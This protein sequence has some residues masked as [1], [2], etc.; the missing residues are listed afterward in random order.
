M[1]RVKKIVRV[2]RPPN[3]SEK[4]VMKLKTII[5]SFTFLTIST[6]LAGLFI[7]YNTMKTTALNTDKIVSET[8]IKNINDSISQLISR[9]NKIALTLS[10]HEEIA[11]ALK[12]D[13]ETRRVQANKILDLFNSSIETSVCYLLNQ[14]GIAIASSNRNDSDSFLGNDYSFRPYYKES[15]KGNSFVYLAYGVTSGRRGIYFSQPVYAPDSGAILGVVVVKEDTDK[16]ENDILF[17]RYPANVAQDDVIVISNEDG[18]VFISGRKELLFNTIWQVDENTTKHIEASKQFGKGPWAWAGFKKIT[19]EKAI[20]PFDTNYNVL[21]SPIKDIPGWNI[22]HFSNSDAVSGRIHATIFTAAGYVFTL[23][24]IMLGFV[25]VL[26]NFLANKAEKKLRESEKRYRSVTQAVSEG[27]ILQA[28]TG[29]ILTWNKGAENIFGIPAK[30][31]IG[32][33]AHGKEWATIYEDGSRFDVKDHPSTR[34]LR[35][36]K[37]CINEIMGIYRPS[38]DLRWISISTNPL[39]G[40]NSEKP[41]AVAISFSDITERKQAAETLRK[42]QEEY[43]STLEGLLAGVVV[44][45]ADSRILYSNPEASRILGLTAGQLSGKTAVDPAWMFVNEDSSPMQVDEYPVSKVLSTRNPLTN[46]VVGIIRPDRGTVTWVNVNARPLFFS[47]GRL[48]KVIVNFVDITDRKKAEEKLRESEAR[49]K[50]LH[51]ASFGGIAIHDKGII[52]D[53]NRGLSEITG[54]SVTELIGMNGLLLIAEKSRD[55]VMENIASGYEKPYEANGLRKNGEEF[56]M[57]L[58]ARNIPYQR[59][60]IRAVEFRDITEQKRAEA[61]RQILQE[62]LTQARKMESVGRLAGGVAHDFNNMLSVILGN[63]EIILEDLDPSS[64]VIPNL[65]E[66]QKAAERSANLTGQLLAF[67]RKQTVSPK[68]LNLNE[69]IDGMLNMLKRLIGEGIDLSWRPETKL[70]PVKID[71]SQVDQILA[72]LSVNA[73]DSIKDI[74]NLTIETDNVHF[75]HKYCRDHMGHTHGDYVMLSVRDSGRGMNK[76]T[77]DNLFEPFFTTKQ[78][79]KGTGLGLATVYGIVKQNKGFI[80]VYSEKDEGTTFRIYLPK[81][82]ETI[83]RKEPKILET[84]VLR[85]HETILLVEDEAS[86]LKMN[87]M[88]LQRL[89]YNVLA[90]STP[91][92]AIQISNDF[93]SGKIELL[94]TDVVMPEMNGRDL[95]E[96]LLRSYPDLKCLFMSG[97]TANVIAH[98]GILDEGLNFISK[99][100]SKQELSTKLRE[101]LDEK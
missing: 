14:D 100:F 36:G 24:F 76:E 52:L 1:L 38:G 99:P 23:I 27:I 43:R 34:T 90:A 86:I 9:Y 12:G 79:G 48:E 15:I 37:A 10:L 73:R 58:E 29:E 87:K 66:V 51:N 20:D 11:M 69:I 72:N 71:P 93:T 16:I 83:N 74:G 35:T 94:M 81:Y 4:N 95:A 13:S 63:T 22:I 80:K 6:V 97:Y 19:K 92:E 31:V 5:W 98:H 17:M 57:R 28:E 96:N 26:L 39:L 54:Y 78:L 64:P 62:Q 59:K 44:H 53:C 88:M 30:D 101:I 50:I 40:E 25:L 32:Q 33:I 84:K 60:N 7:Y 42:G 56:P 61:E 55:F 77:M 85:G 65:H 18:V 75:D 41:Y 68:I 82:A 8:Q 21:L 70:W 45:D 49:F 89:G 47:D 91:G 3:R 46:Y 67:A 2:A